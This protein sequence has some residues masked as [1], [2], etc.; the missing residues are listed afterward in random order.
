[1]RK[2]TAADIGQ[3]NAVVGVGSMDDLTVPDIYPNV[4]LMPESKPPAF[5]DVSIVPLSV[6]FSS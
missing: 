3:N 6:A 4:T 1:M 2:A 5:R